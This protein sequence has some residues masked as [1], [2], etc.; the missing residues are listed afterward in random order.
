MPFIAVQNTLSPT[1]IPIST[2]LLSFTQTLGGAI[3][4]SIGEAVFSAS[5]Q[6]DVPK[7]AEG[8]DATAV[9]AAGATKLK[10]VFTSPPQLAGILIAYSKGL[11]RVFYVAVGCSCAC[12][13]FAWGLGWQDIR[14]KSATEKAQVDAT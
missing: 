3:I 14:K 5:L 4:L 7:Y 12:F 2:S 10:E 1:L 8:V 9:V 11:N 6:D 13:L